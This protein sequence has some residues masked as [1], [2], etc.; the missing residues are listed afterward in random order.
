MPEF[1]VDTSEQVG[2]RLDHFL[3]RR[4]SDHSR[5]ALGRLICSGAI[6]VNDLQ[7]KAGYRLRAK[8]TI[9]VV[10]PENEVT[11]L[12]GQPI[13]FDILYE[14]DD[15]LVVNKPAGL[16]VHPGAGNRQGTLVNGL[17]YR[18]PSLP[19]NDPERPGIVHRLDK[20]T[21][22]I[23]LVAKSENG[24]RGLGESF[25]NRLISKTYHA[26]LLRHPDQESGR[27]VAPIGRHP[28]HRKK[29]TIREHGGRYAATSWKVLQSW[30]GFCFVDVDLETGRTHQIRVHMASLGSPVAGDQLYG[31]RVK[32]D[33]GLNIHRQLLHAS[34][35][36]F[37]HPVTGREM[38]FTAPLP[39]DM[40][41]VI[42]SLNTR[43]SLK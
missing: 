11:A 2:L 18:Y 22:G 12:L 17:L 4:L 25:K 23:L 20:D 1:F 16:V 36:R 9:T 30:P 3:V 41:H 8:D 39:D 14:D 13:A 42:S 43:N 6:R 28:V 21:S 15:L 10:Y 37:V 33:S 32:M 27:L 19:G 35:L 29:M 5:A 31:G 38:Q 26:V 34:T 7:V 40:Q 24:L